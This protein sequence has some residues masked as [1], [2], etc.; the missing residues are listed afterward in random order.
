VINE[1][2]SFLE[3]DKLQP[4]PELGC[5]GAEECLVPF[6]GSG[7]APVRQIKAKGDDFRVLVCR[8]DCV[9][10]IYEKCVATPLE[11]VLDE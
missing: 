9:V 6:E 3:M 7:K 10:Q 4:W 5:T 2:G 1:A 8:V 11:V